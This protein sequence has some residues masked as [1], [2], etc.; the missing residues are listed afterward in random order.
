M[1][2]DY[3][4]TFVCREDYCKELVSYESPIHEGAVWP[5][6]GE[7][8]LPTHIIGS[9]DLTCPRGHTKTYTIRTPIQGRVPPQSPPPRHYKV[10]LGLVNARQ[11]Y[12]QENIQLLAYDA[13]D[14]VFQVSLKLDGI[15]KCNPSLSFSIEC[16]EPAAPKC[17]CKTLSDISTW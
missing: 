10:T 13:R 8:T 9:T 4:N 5:L 17:D 2:T 15:V 7:K 1:L 14:A 11:E 6:P 12:K 16:I 3:I